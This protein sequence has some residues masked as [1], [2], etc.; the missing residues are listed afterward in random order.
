MAKHTQE[1]ILQLGWEVLPHAAYSPD[2]APTDFHLFRSMQHELAG[3]RFK[4]VD[5]IRDFVKN[6]LASKPISFYRSGI[7]QLP[8]RWQKVISNN[9]YYVDD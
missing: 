3:C 9:G 4:N 6:Y 5:Q 8:E 1:T 7:R 2:L